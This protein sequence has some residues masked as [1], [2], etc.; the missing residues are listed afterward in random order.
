[1][2]Q[3]PPSSFTSA[4]VKRGADWLRG[5]G[6]ES[7]VVVSSRV[8]LARNLA[9]F[10]FLT[11]ASR[12][13]RQAVLDVCRERLLCAGIAPQVLWVDVH[14]APV[15]DRTLMVERHLISKEHA[16]GQTPSAKGQAAASA[17]SNA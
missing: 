14:S 11:R 4:A 10:P 3:V 9:G 6:A 2:S 1:M 17:E 8:R 16:R 15:L 7:D 5:S 13:H 12:Q